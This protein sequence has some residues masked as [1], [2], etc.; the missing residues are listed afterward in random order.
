MPKLRA[1]NQAEN[2]DAQSSPGYRLHRLRHDHKCQ[3]RRGAVSKGSQTR[4]SRIERPKRTL[5]PGQI[6]YSPEAPR[7]LTFMPSRG[8]STSCIQRRGSVLLLTTAF[9]L[10]A[11]WGSSRA[12]HWSG[13]C[14]RRNWHPNYVRLDF[15]CSRAFHLCRLARRP[16]VPWFSATLCHEPK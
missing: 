8:T 6:L 11:A 15:V 13:P 4:E 3:H 1:R 2:R 5:S 7:V 16:S 14:V 9:I 12:R 10:A